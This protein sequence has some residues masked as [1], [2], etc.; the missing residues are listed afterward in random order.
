MLKKSGEIWYDA[1]YHGW[2]ILECK[3]QGM[4]FTSDNEGENNSDWIES[5]GQHSLLCLF[6][7]DTHYL[8]RKKKQKTKTNDNRFKQK[9][10]TK[11]F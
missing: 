5:V 6:T 9:H 11:S 7:C 10:E 1:Y 2:P 8:Q 3:E 4:Q